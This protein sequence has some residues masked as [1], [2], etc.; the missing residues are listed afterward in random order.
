MHLW[1]SRGICVSKKVWKCGMEWWSQVSRDLVYCLFISDNQDQEHNFFEV[2]VWHIKT[3]TT[4]MK[5]IETGREIKCLHNYYHHKLHIM[6]VPCNKDLWRRKQSALFVVVLEKELQNPRAILITSIFE[7]SIVYSMKK[8]DR[9]HLLS[10]INYLTF[11][12]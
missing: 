12:W 3:W 11:C 8:S 2:E 4:T 10:T 9:N 5:I 7:L 1:C 6:C